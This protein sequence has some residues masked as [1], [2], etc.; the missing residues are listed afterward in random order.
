LFDMNTISTRTEKVT[1][2]LSTCALLLFLIPRFICLIFIRKPETR[3]HV[4]RSIGKRLRIYFETRGGLF[5]KFGQLISHRQDIFPAALCEEL[6]P[7]TEKVPAFDSAIA[8]SIINQ[9]SPQLSISTFETTPLGSASIAQVH[10]AVLTDGSSVAIKVQR[11]NIETEIRRDL[12]QLQFFVRLFDG[13]GILPK[14]QEIFIEFKTWLLDQELDFLKEVANLEKA[15]KPLSFRPFFDTNLPMQTHVPKVYP[16]FSTSK[17]LIMEFIDGRTLSSIATKQDLTMLERKEIVISAL[18]EFLSQ[19]VLGNFF[20]ADPHLS[21]LI[22]DNRT[23]QIYFLDWGLVGTFSNFQA[24]SLLRMYRGFVFRN[25][26]V[27][28]D[29]VTSLMQMS[30][31][32]KRRIKKEFKQLFYKFNADTAFALDRP[33]REVG[34]EFLT[35][36][37]RMLIAHRIDI[38]SEAS[39]AFKTMA[40][41]DAVYTAVYPELTVR[42]MFATCLEVSQLFVT[43]IWSESGLINLLLEK[44][45]HLDS[46]EAIDITH[47]M[48]RLPLFGSVVKEKIEELKIIDSEHNIDEL[49]ENTT[50]L[51]IRLQQIEEIENLWLS[52]QTPHEIEIK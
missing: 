28:W 16:Q 15:A 31:H 33:Y 36:L 10:K 9:E 19:F 26:N 51:N 41:T 24:L 5:P 6:L 7:L 45:V 29:G 40:T 44:S 37:M 18:R 8:R 49:I 32:D 30:D 39:L 23:K 14:L 17:V 20:Q 38:P 50:E 27:C 22:L 42:D 48:R 11:P 35:T 43:K 13:L 4:L 34:S 52:L 12:R 1:L 47:D 21:N 25:S 46:N 2:L 3:E